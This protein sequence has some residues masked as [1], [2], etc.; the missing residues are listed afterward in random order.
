MSLRWIGIAGALGL[1]CG[2]AA[3]QPEADPLTTFVDTVDVEVVNVEVVVTDR[4]GRPVGGLT[5]GDFTISEAGEPVEITN[6][7]AVSGG[8]PAGEPP[9]REVV[10]GPSLPRPPHTLPEDQRLNL[11][12]YIDNYN[13]EPIERN[14]LLRQVEAFLRQ[15]LEHGARIMVASFDRG[16]VKVLT[17]LTAEPETVFGALAEVERQVGER[18]HQAAARRRIIHDLES[19]SPGDAE[20]AVLLADTRRQIELYAQE[21]HAANRAGAR[22]LKLF[23]SSLAGLPGRKALVH[24][25]SG[26]SMRPGEELFHAFS[27][28]LRNIQGPG[29]KG[30]DPITDS[31]TYDLS[32]E[33]KDLGRHANAQRVTFYTLNAAG[34]TRFAAISA[35]YSGSAFS[36]T[37]VW[38]QGE[39]AILRE[40]DNAPLAYLAHLTGGTAI[41][42]PNRFDRVVER[43][44][45]DF[46]NFYSLGY[47]RH[48]ES[49]GSYRKLKVRVSRKGLEVRHRRGYRQKTLREKAED[50]LYS[51][52]LAG[53]GDNALGIELELGQREGDG[54]RRSRLPLLVR[55]PISEITLL[56]LEETLEGRFLVF[57]AVRDAEGRMSDV[58]QTQLPLSIPQDGLRQAL[59]QSFG[60]ETELL[61]R[62]GPHRVAVG[63][64]DLLS[65]VSSFVTAD[66]DVDPAHPADG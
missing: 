5:R 62:R 26:I 57:V 2:G 41:L 35:A 53:G 25:S 45:D 55:V 48:P 17:P 40:N 12:L 3:G 30:F 18:V 8:V 23:V 36:T 9:P 13:I 37:P 47:L 10:G 33:F 58:K 44:A 27:N 14:R 16:G 19:I 4:K 15:R 46:D 11:V 65:N 21:T 28:A 56:P 38:G 63:V 6:F 1:L 7:Y 50:R 61:L 34:G 60:Y 66:F 29:P 20:S 31:L 42:N 22:V 59:A 51:A 64:H 24:V 54:K 52:L 43:L 39:A 32:P 49:T